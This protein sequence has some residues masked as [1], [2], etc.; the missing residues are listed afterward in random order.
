MNKFKRVSFLTIFL[1]ALSTFLVEAR[2]L[3]NITRQMRFIFF[4]MSGTQA[5]SVWL[6]FAMFIIIFA[7]LYNGGLKAMKAEGPMKRALAVIAFVVALT[8]AIFVPYKLLLYI[9]RLYS[10]ILIVLFAMLPAA[11]GFAINHTLL[12]GDS[13]MYRILRAIVYFMITIFIFGVIGTVD[14]L[15]SPEKAMYEQVLEPLTYGAI[16]AFIAGIFNLLMAMGGD[17]VAEAIGK[18]FGKEGAGTPTS[19]APGAAAPGT[20]TPPAPP[21]PAQIQALMNAMGNFMQSVTGTGGL[22]EQ[23]QNQWT[24]Y[25]QI[26]TQP[27]SLAKQAAAQQFLASWNYGAV[28]TQLNTMNTA[29]N[30][31]LSNAQYQNVRTVNEPIQQQFERIVASFVQTSGAFCQLHAVAIREAS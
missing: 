15:S 19:P 30:T 24:I 11:I 6:K 20:P 4:N 5:F 10:A 8:S 18:R 23:Y 28:Q 21:N 26:H 9:F 25:E 7:V 16:I 17:K 2:V 31:I 1:F 12:K 13:R 27:V 22:N 3:D 29:L 14:S